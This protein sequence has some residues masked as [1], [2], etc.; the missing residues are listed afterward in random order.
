MVAFPEDRDF[1]ATLPG[2][3]TDPGAQLVSGGPSADGLNTGAMREQARER[4]FGQRRPKHFG[5][6]E[7]RERLGAGG[8]GEVFAVWD[9]DLD[10][11]VALKVLH[12]LGSRSELASARLLRE[13]KLMARIDHPNVVVVHEAGM[14]DGRVYLAME[15][16]DGVT[17]TDWLREGHVQDEV[18]DVFRQAARGL[19]AAHAAGLIHRDFKP[20]NVMVSRLDLG[21]WR[22]RVMDFGL[23]YIDRDELEATSDEGGFVAEAPRLTHDGA[24][25]GTP[26]YMAPEQHEGGDVDARADQWAFAISLHEALYERRPFTGTTYA[27]LVHN[28]LHAPIPEPPKGKPVPRWIRAVIVRGL[29]RDPNARFESMARMVAALEADPTRRRGALVATVLVVGLGALAVSGWSRP[30]DDAAQRCTEPSASALALWSETQRAEVRTAFGEASASGFEAFDHTMNAYLEDWHAEYR[31]ACEATHVHGEQ[32]SQLLDRRMHCLD[33][34]LRE[35]SAL[36]KALSDVDVATLDRAVRAVQ[37]LPRPEVCGDRSRLLAVADTPTDAVLAE[38]VEEVDASLAE[39]R[40]AYDLGRHAE[41]IALGEELLARAEDLEWGPLTAAVH[42][43]L[44][45]ALRASVQS[46]RA[47]AEFTAA[48]REALRAGDDLLAARAAA[49]MIG[50]QGAYLDDRPRGEEWAADAQALVDRIGGDTEL[51]AT[52][53]SSRGVLADIAGETATAEDLYDRALE[54]RREVFGEDHP[55]VA[56]VHVNLGAAAIATGDLDAASE[57]FRHAAEIIERSLGPEHGELRAPITN[58][59]IVEYYRGED[60]RAREYFERALAITERAEGKD[61]PA[62]LP[63]LTNLGATCGRRL[64]Y[65]DALAHYER[66]LRIGIPAYG[67]R[68]PE[69]AILR[70]NIG[71]TLNSLGEHEQARTELETTVAIYEQADGHEANLERARTDL[72]EVLRKL[73]ESSKARQL[74][75]DML[76]SKERRLGPDDGALLSNLFGLA[77]IER[78]A[79]RTSASRKLYRRIEG[80]LEHAEVSPLYRAQARLGLAELLEQLDNPPGAREQARRGLDALLEA[81][82]GHTPLAEEARDRASGGN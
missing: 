31:R 58:L 76:G 25:M 63:V 46:K 71:I 2:D 5:R 16:I 72:A 43:E 61:S 81:D 41:A 14:T 4:L 22:A 23:A 75:L 80:L 78:E 40:A 26:A 42:H 34:G 64:D 13:A 11:E 44:G 68:H 29:A 1:D 47:A 82:L 62:L 33:Q 15:R 49:E 55:L 27:N 60:K 28:V 50:V 9:P 65:D 45:R 17:L 53:W 7:L 30:G 10:R 74:H 3:V 20:D 37:N 12:E 6:Y 48:Y 36:V 52:V 77:E 21:G 35:A 56:D 24:I 51:Q 54:L 8:M 32:S 67:E 39:V 57:S 79:G 69:I 19:A 18:L 73:G 59:G 70:H 38:A 66:A